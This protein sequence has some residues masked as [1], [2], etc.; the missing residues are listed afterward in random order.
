[1]KRTILTTAAVLAFV[2]PAMATDY[3]FQEVTAVSTDVYL[4]QESDNWDQTGTPSAGD[5]VII[6]TG[7]RAVVRGI[8]DTCGYVEVA[9]GGL[10]YIDGSSATATLTIDGATT[11]RTSTIARGSVGIQLIGSQAKLQVQNY[12]HTFSPSGA[13]TDLARIDG[14]HDQASISI[15]TEDESITISDGVAVQGSLEIRADEGTFINNGMIDADSGGASDHTLTCYNGTY[16]GT[17]TYRVSDPDSTLS[18]TDDITS[19]T[20]LGS[21]FDVTAGTLDIAVDVSTTGD[22]SF[23]SGTIVIGSDATFSFNQ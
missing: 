17:G 18:F 1:M 9:S 2:L 12:N 19:A 3:T 6:P 22:L 21:N 8:A 20:G 15:V 11:P 14:Q 23:T 13:G 16:T 7:T 4:W 10:V 5:R